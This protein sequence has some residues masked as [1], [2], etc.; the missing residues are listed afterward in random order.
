MAATLTHV[1]IAMKVR[2]LA[3]VGAFRKEL[4][5]ANLTPGEI[6]LVA[7]ECGYD[8]VDAADGWSVVLS[9]STLLARTLRRIAGALGDDSS[10]ARVPRHEV[11][12]ALVAAIDHACPGHLDHYEALPEGDSLDMLLYMV[13]CACDGDWVDFS[14]VTDWIAMNDREAAIQNALKASVDCNLPTASLLRAIGMSGLRT[15][16][17][18][19]VL[20]AVPFIAGGKGEPVRLLGQRPMPSRLKQND[21]STFLGIEA[22][23]DG[24]RLLIEYRLTE[25]AVE[26]S[27]FHIPPASKQIVAGSYEEERSRTTVRFNLETKHARKLAGLRTVI[28]RLYPDYV[29]GQRAFVLLDKAAGTA[30]VEVVDAIDHDSRER[31]RSLLCE[32]QPVM[33]SMAA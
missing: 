26:T 32:A 10:L 1:D 25:Q 16:F 6:G 33:P 11:V 18:D 3:S 17:N 19:A 30:H 22:S 13:G 28:L 20:P 21:G 12:R 4:V 24:C 9:S 31:L 2:A 8:L 29:A 5:C 7:A 23:D 14:P 15:T 27:S